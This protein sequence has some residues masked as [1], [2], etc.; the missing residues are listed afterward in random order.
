MNLRL[1][2]KTFLVTGATSGFGHSVSGR[3]LAEGAKIIVVARTESKIREM[4]RASDAV[5]GIV[6][7]VTQSDILNKIEELVNNITIDGAFINAGGPPAGG[8][9]DLNLED[10]DK[11]FD[12]VIRWKVDLIK[13]LLPVFL[14]QKYGRLVFLESA[15]VK[16]PIENLIL[17]NSLR[18]SIIG[19]IKSLT[20]EIAGEG[21]TINTIAPGYHKT[22][23]VDRLIN[24]AA[25]KQ[26]IS[27]DQ[28]AKQLENRIPVGKAGD[29]DKLASL[30]AWLLS[31][32]SEFVT[33]QIFYLDGGIIRASL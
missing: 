17:S 29:P 10:W 23:A 21:V 3:L 20:C 28:A 16:Q 25:E 27:T 1:R 2:D 26:S 24:K 4:E 13:R 5:T 22:Q 31:E 8:F 15:S 30:A 32:E 11:G 9:F 7:D 33:G 14:K 18:M 12:L 19:L 6:G